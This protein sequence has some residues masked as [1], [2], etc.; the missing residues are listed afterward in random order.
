MAITVGIAGITGK[1]ARR[2]VHHLLQKPDVNIRGYARDPSK[3]SAALRNSSRI[4]VTPGEADDAPALRSFVQGSDVVLCAYLGNDKLMIDGQKALI[5][6]CETE[7]VPRYIASDYSLDYRK[8]ELGQLPSKDPMK[9][10][11]TYLQEKKNVQGVHVLIGIFMDTFWSQFFQVWNDKE[12]KLSYWG[13]GDEKW[14][15][16]SYDNAAQFVAQIAL[17]KSA[18]GFHNFIGDKKTTKEIAAIFESVYGKKPQLQ[19]LGTLDELKSKMYQMAKEDP[20]AFMNY[21]PLFYQYY[22]TNGQTYLEDS[23]GNTRYPD[24]KAVT[25]E[26]YLRTHKMEELSTAAWAVGSDV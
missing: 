16:T 15:S 11:E 7:N 10:I 2:V 23:N 9:K 5:D 13:T 21:I 12:V 20:S 18:V 25:F 4:Q 6:A 3:L 1:F 24:I 26:D 8:L 14:E 17:D 22:C 19:S